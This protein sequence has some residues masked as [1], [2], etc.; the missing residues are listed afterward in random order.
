[1][2]LKHLEYFM[3]V[4]EN[5]NFSKAAE[6]LFV[7]QP[8]ISKYIQELERELGVKLF[9]RYPRKVVLNRY[10]RYFYK[11]V[12]KI[13]HQLEN[14][15]KTIK[16]MVNPFFGTINLSFIH[17]LGDTLI[18]QIISEYNSNFPDVKFNLLQ[19]S[20]DVLLKDL[21]EGGADFCFLMDREFPDG[22]KHKKLF[23][24]TLYAALPKD[25]PF[26][27][28]TE[29]DLSLLKNES[30]INFKL[31]IG[32]RNSIDSICK[33]A[34][35][36]PKVKFECQEVGT[37]AGFVESGLGVSLI[38]YIKGIDRYNIA[39]LPLTNKYKT[40]NINLAFKKDAFFSPSIRQFYMFL[41]TKFNL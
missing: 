30:F 2:K 19:G 41:N 15:E 16:E 31:G 29:I 7:S 33:T 10:G 26:S 17:T 3:S 18:P 25:H 34:G 1:M 9:D 28:L 24:E 38:P 14:T 23:S 32:L 13:L 22:I 20:T 5:H 27:S 37:V 11:E 6:K 39:V 4:A 36:I 12:K 21:L 35:F 8:N 40:R